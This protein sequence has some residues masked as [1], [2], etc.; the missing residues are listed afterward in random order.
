MTVVAVAPV[1]EV[2]NPSAACPLSGERS[3]ASDS[4][5]ESDRVAL[6]V[7]DFVASEVTQA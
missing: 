4:R 1:E 5:D 3:S 7:E 6:G 2:Y